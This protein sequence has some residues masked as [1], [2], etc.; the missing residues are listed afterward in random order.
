MFKYT[1]ND[2][3]ITLS[4]FKNFV[5]SIN[6]DF[7]P[8]LLERINI[9]EY[10]K[11][12]TSLATII[13]CRENNNIIGFCA[14]YNND[15]KN[16]IGYIT[17]VGVIKAFR[18]KGIASNLISHAKKIAKANGMNRIY[19]HT[20]SPIAK[21]CYQSAGFSIIEET[22]LRDYHVIRYLLEINI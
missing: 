10:Y 16:Q 5:E 6:P 22:V 15:Y 7:T 2:K 20:N 9:S 8:S 1:D 14:M 3:D 12:L 4:E 17:L 19:I 11:K 21:S 18:H 13:T